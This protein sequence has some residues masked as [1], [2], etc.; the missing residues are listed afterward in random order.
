MTWRKMGFSPYLR[1]SR[2]AVARNPGA[3]KWDGALERRRILLTLND[4]RIIIAC[5]NGEGS[6]LLYYIL[7]LR[8]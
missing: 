2:L 6:L 7:P 3:A 1:G 5:C 8:A 4:Y